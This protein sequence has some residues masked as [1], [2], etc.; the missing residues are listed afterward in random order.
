MT[1]PIWFIFLI[2]W[3]Y[4]LWNSPNRCKIACGKY[5]PRLLHHIQDADRLGAVRAI[6]LMCESDHRG[7]YE[8]IDHCKRFYGDQY[9]QLVPQGSEKALVKS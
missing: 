9:D 7:D 4:E 6:R 5:D 1:S 3:K 8:A 2:F